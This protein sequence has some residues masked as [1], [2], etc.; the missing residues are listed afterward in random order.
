MTQ[1]INSYCDL[2]YLRLQ[3]DLHSIC[4]ICV[5]SVSVFWTQISLIEQ[6]IHLRVFIKFIRGICV[7]CGRFLGAGFID[8]TK[9]ELL[10]FDLRYLRHLRQACICLC[11]RI[12]L[13]LNNQLQTIGCQLN[14]R[15]QLAAHVRMQA[16][17]V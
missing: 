9:D 17:L 2:R 10:A 14:V 3:I 4:D 16:Q 1:M 11:P 15:R 7:I 12:S 8:R 13:D 6:M 5:R